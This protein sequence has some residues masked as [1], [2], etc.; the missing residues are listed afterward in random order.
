M[1]TDITGNF[2]L[3]N[4]VAL[5][6]GTTRGLGQSMAEA[7]AQAGA[8]VVSLDRSQNDYLPNYC[9]SSGLKFKRIRID[10]LHATEAELKKVIDSII[11]DF[12]RIDILVNNAGITRRGEVEDFREEDWLD[13]LKVNLTVPFYLSKIVSK[14]FI[15]QKSGK[16]IN[17]ASMLS[18]Q[19]GLRVP[20]YA[21][22]K[23][24]IIGLTKSFANGLAPY[25]INVNAIAPG[26]MATDLTLPLQQDKDRN[27][28]II[29]RTP[30]GR[31]G[32]DNDLNGTLIYLASS[33]SGYVNG[34]VI[35]VDGGWLAK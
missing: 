2:S 4:K 25:G 3:K 33:M 7:L 20:S 22:S 18:F 34:T 27:D 16:I 24:G 14:Y 23:H 31:W 30:M 5:I 17:I 12:S 35:P 32:N 19:G 28:L 15:K 11:N 6:T 21:A 8:S 26:F 10:L 29:K 1:K 13:V 9:A